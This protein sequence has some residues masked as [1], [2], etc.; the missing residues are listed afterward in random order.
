MAP[1]EH[2]E[3]KLTTFVTCGDFFE[4][5]DK[6]LTAHATQIDPV[7]GWFHVPLEIRKEV[8]PTE[9]YE[10]AK[11][12]VDTSLPEDDLF[13]G[14]R[15]Q[16]RTRGVGEGGNRMDSRPGGSLIRSRSS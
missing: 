3:R 9:E 13:S 4:I 16:P 8:W 7:G 2:R 6:A 14:L 15:S 11:S 5:R 12:L 10:L 1:F